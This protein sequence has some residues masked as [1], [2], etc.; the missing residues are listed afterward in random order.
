MSF[1]KFI[2]PALPDHYGFTLTAYHLDSE[3]CAFEPPAW[4]LAVKL[5]NSLKGRTPCAVSPLGPHWER[6]AWGIT[7]PVRS[8]VPNQARRYP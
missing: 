5:W 3:L 1:C 6:R 2:G 4:T 8:P 7:R